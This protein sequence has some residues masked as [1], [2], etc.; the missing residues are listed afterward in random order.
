MFARVMKPGAKS[1][2][3]RFPEVIAIGDLQPQQGVSVVVWSYSKLVFFRAGSIRLSH[4]SGI[5]DVTIQEAV[6]PFWSWM[7]RNWAF[8]VLFA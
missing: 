4:S 3:L 5:G 1:D 6:G 8:L 7:D 2:D